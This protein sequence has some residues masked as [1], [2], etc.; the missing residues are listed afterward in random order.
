MPQGHSPRTVLLASAVAG[1]A[2]GGRSS[3]GP[4]VTCFVGTT[5]SWARAGAVTGVAVELVG[6]KLPRTP[7][8]LGLAP[9]TGRVV[10]GGVT[11]VLLARARR[12]RGAL[13]AVAGAGGALA[14]SYAGA[15]WRAAWAR[16]GRPDLPA[17][18]IE[19]AVAIGLAYAAYRAV[20]SVPTSSA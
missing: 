16:S 3:L 4:V 14:G 15:A 17:A 20:S 5:S 12:V 13:P 8:R 10:A 11:G 1:L 7:D 9:L 19:D 6:D 2:S 18:I